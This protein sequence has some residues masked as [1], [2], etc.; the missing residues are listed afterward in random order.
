MM[1]RWLLLFVVAMGGSRA[2]ASDSSPVDQWIDAHLNEVV[3]LYKVLHKS[4]ELSYEEAQTAARMATELKQLDCEV[5]TNLGGHGVIGILRNGPGKTLMLRADMDAL[6]VVEQTGLDY[7]SQVK[8]EDR[9][10]ATVG[11]MHAC[12]HDIHMANLVGVARMLAAHRDLWSGTAIFLFQ[13]AEERGAGAKAMLEDGLFVKYPRPDFAVA[14]H[15]AADLP[16]GT[17]STLPGFVQAN[18]DSVDIT[19]NGRGGHGAYPETTIDPVVIAAKLVL[20]LQTVVSREIKATDPAV[21]TVGSI[22]AGTKHNIIA[23]DC[24]LQLTVR[25]YSPEVRQ[26]LWSAI[27]RK[28]KAAADS[29]GAPEPEI[30]IGEG[31]PSLYNDPELTAQVLGSLESTLGSNALVE[32]PPTMGGEDFSRYGLAGVPICM[33]KLGSV[34]PARLKEFEKLQTPPPSLHSPLYYPQPAETLAAGIKS[35]GHI[36]LSLLAPAAIAP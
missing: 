35:M 14:L 3:E 1:F 30:K 12:G 21:I 25:S 9:R 29:A 6:P 34:S 36:A 26:Q 24:K 27:R 22:Q 32:S 10:G 5:V 18:V 7:A 20:D 19:I 2:V 8:T 16:A 23:D 11:V 4:P 15:V 28:A 33:Y 31:T 17:V 13:P